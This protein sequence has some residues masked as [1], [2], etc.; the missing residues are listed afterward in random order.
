M[1]DGNS[2]PSQLWDERNYLNKRSDFRRYEV[3]VNRAAARR[4][5]SIS[6]WF[7]TNWQTFHF[8]TE[9]ILPAPAAVYLHLCDYNIKWSNEYGL[10]WWETPARH[11]L[12]SVTSI[13]IFYAYFCLSTA[14]SAVQAQRYVIVIVGQRLAPES[15]HRWNDN[16]TNR[17]KFSEFS[18]E[19]SSTARFRHSRGN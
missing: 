3:E 14:R 16:A 7:V 11:G 18:L 1:L 17:L 13:F 8:I 4:K 5:N 2:I 6:Y 10:D 9:C 15:S 12:A 19:H